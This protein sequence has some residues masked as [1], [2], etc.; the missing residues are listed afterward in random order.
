MVVEFPAS[1]RVRQKDD[2]LIRQ[3]SR[4]ERNSGVASQAGAGLGLPPAPRRTGIGASASFTHA[5]QMA[6]NGPSAAIPARLGQRRGSGGKSPFVGVSEPVLLSHSRCPPSIRVSGMKRRDLM[7]LLG[8]AAITWPRPAPAH[9]RLCW[10][11]D[12]STR[13]RPTVRHCRPWPRSIRDSAMPV[14][15]R[16]RTWRSNTAGRR[17]TMIG[18]PR[19]PPTSPAARSI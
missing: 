1:A 10:R 19:L 11:S 17:A 13:G 14:T 2:A 5:E 8:G 15:L 18:C 12:T 9:R 3:P 7:L 16:G 6:Q 4:R